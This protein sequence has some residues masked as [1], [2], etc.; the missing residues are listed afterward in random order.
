MIIYSSSSIGGAGYIAIEELRS[1][2]RQNVFESLL[3]LQLKKLIISVYT[4]KNREESLKV[5]WKSVADK[6]K[7]YLVAALC[8]LA[9]E[10]R[11]K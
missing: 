2:I 6:G 3:A 1:T 7:A 11:L 8:A 10:N 4:R 5:V 9:P